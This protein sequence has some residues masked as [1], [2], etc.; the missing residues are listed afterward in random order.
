MPVIPASSK[1]LLTGGTGFLGIWT[2]KELL[3]RGFTVR[4][5][6]RS[7]SKAEHIRNALKEHIE[8]LEFVIVDDITQ[9]GAFDEA[10]KGVDGIIHSASP[11]SSGDPGLDPN[12]LIEPAVNGTIGII[13]SALKSS[14]VQRV[15][16][17]SSIM[18]IW[19]PKESP[20]V[21]TE[22][23][24]NDAAINIVKE[25]GKEAPS[26]MK[27]A[28]SKSL[29]ER[30][31]WELMKRENP[32]F[33]LVTI[34]PSF[35]WGEILSETTA[36]IKGSNSVL[37][38]PLKK[39]IWKTLDDAQLLRE[40]QAVDVRDTAKLHV[41]AL[42]HPAAS[43]QRFIC[44]SDNITIQH[45]FDALNSNP[46]DG[47]AVPKG[48]PELLQ[49]WTVQVNFMAQKSIDELGMSY[50]PLR[51]TIHDTIIHALK[52]GWHQ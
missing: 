11:L 52:L 48:K 3:E 36:D 38:G 45:I 8:H 23:D 17:T 12:L 33:D 6:I 49:D 27:Y 39:E 5:A 26:F 19:E 37:L 13:K 10:V 16:I 30:A 1:V 42:Q 50:R 9:P 46:I 51:E 14:T 28:A 24:W 40:V 43:N 34:L 44:N 4:A 18:A 31:A 2:L 21:Y 41:D 22:A 35:I 20:S 29:A 15:V 32:A 25:K 7:E 47:L